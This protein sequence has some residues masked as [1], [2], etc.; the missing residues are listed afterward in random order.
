M[1]TMQSFIRHARIR[2]DVQWADS[3]GER[4]CSNP[5]EHE[6]GG[7][8]D[9]MATFEDSL[10][11]QWGDEYDETLRYVAQHGADTGHPGLTYYRD[12]VALYEAHEGEIWDALHED[13]GE[14]GLDH[15]LALIATFGGAVNVG[16]QDQL[17]NL[18]VWYMA[19][20]IAHRA[21]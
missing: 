3:N 6:P 9:S 7:T 4:G 2:A 13:A 12:T 8:L 10:R 5:A 11:E 1:A 21:E 14:M 20:R 17:A 16:S 19:E 18:L 15:P